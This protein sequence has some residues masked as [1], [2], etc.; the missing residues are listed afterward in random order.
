MR[1]RTFID[2]SD[3]ADGI[4]RA[5]FDGAL[6]IEGLSTAAAKTLKKIMGKDYKVLSGEIAEGT[7]VTGNQHIYLKTICFYMSP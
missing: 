3:D 4:A 2:D 1:L 6:D 5:K 7:V